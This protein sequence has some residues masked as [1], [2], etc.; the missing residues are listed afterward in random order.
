MVIIRVKKEDHP[1][2]LD[3]LMRCGAL[4]SHTSLS[5]HEDGNA[6]NIKVSFS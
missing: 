1:E 2:Y 6:E 3:W 5:K 4:V